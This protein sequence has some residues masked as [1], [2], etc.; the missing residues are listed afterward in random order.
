MFLKDGWNLIRLS[1]NMRI[2]HISVGS[3]TT[4]RAKGSMALSP[5]FQHSGTS[6]LIQSRFCM[7]NGVFPF[8]LPQSKTR[9][10]GN[11]DWLNPFPIRHDLNWQQN[12]D[13]VQAKGS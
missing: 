13:R 1:P 11:N 3:V 9:L 5:L 8:A 6:T 4:N 12:P 2:Q 7:L 10:I